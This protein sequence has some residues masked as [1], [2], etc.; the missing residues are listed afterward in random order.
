LLSNKLE[1]VKLTSL[2]SV[3]AVSES[4][5]LQSNSYRRGSHHLFSAAV[6]VGPVAQ[7]AGKPGTGGK[8]IETLRAGQACYAPAAR[9]ADSHTCISF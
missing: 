4:F 1:V 9:H 7:P 2:G 8:K 5:D 3:V 6:A